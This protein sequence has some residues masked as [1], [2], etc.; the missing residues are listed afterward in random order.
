MIKNEKSTYFDRKVLACAKER[1]LGLAEED[2]YTTPLRAPPE[3]W[4]NL[5]FTSIGI[6]AGEFETFLDDI[7]TFVQKLKV[8]ASRSLLPHRTCHY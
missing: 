8:R 7:T 5:P 3:W 2:V 6:V 4:D 1:Y